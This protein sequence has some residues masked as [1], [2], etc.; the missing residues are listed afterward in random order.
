MSGT[1]GTSRR[2]TSR[3]NCMV[4]PCRQRPGGLDDY[5]DRTRCPSSSCRAR[6]Q[7]CDSSGRNRCGRDSLSEVTVILDDRRAWQDAILNA[8]SRGTQHC[9]C[10]HRSPTPWVSSSW[11]TCPGSHRTVRAGA[12]TSLTGTSMSSTSSSKCTWPSCSKSDS[13]STLATN[14]RPGRLGLKRPCCTLSARKSRVLGGGISY[15]PSKLR[16]IAGWRDLG[17]YELESLRSRAG[18]LESSQRREPDGFV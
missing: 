10:H 16:H 11:T 3:S 6:V 15:S 8:P 18:R 2:G 9:G 4:E 14:A 13:V 12:A 1:L 17:R 7:T 5:T